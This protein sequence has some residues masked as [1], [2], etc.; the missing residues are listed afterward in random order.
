MPAYIGRQLTIARDGV[1]IAGVRTKSV[2]IGNEA[3]DVTTD[4]DTGYRTLLE[5]PA[6]KQV[7]LSVEGL[8]KDDEL[9]EEAADGTTLIKAC[10]ITFPS[11]ATVTGDFRFNNLE[12]GAEFN[13]AIT[14]TAEV[15]STGPYTFTAAP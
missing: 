14:F 13:A 5:D 10:T 7:D 6:Q 1:N 4:D 15:Q 8:M 9:L 11:G 3:V 12:L 2:T